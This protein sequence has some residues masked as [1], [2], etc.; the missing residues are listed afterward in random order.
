MM[1]PIAS[2]LREYNY[3]TT[4]LGTLKNLS[5][6]DPNAEFL[7][8][9]E[10]EQLVDKYAPRTAFITKTATWTYAEFDLYAN[11]VANWAVDLR[12]V[13]GDTVALFTRNRLEYVA[14]WYG[15]SKVGV[16]AALVNDLLQGKGLAHCLAVAETKIMLTEPGLMDA[17]ISANSHLPEALSLWCFDGGAKGSQDFDTAIS[18]TSVERPT[19]HLRAG[20]TGRETLLKMFTSGTTG[21][22]K[23]VKVSHVRAQRYMHSFSVATG[24]CKTDR[25]MMVLPMYH[26]TGGLCGVGTALTVGAAV[27]VEQG[28]SARKF[29]QTAAEHDATLFTYVGE[30][31]RFLINTET[32]PA[33]TKHSIRAMLGNGLRPEVWTEFQRRF[34][35]KTIAEFYGATEGNV[36]LMNADGQVGAMG[37]IPWYVKKAFNL[38][39][40][41]HDFETSEVVRA[42]DGSC[43]RVKLGDAGE[44]I[45]RIDPNDPRFLF[46]GYGNAKDTKN[47]ILT[48]VFEPGDRYF[49]TGDLM[50]RDRKAYYYFV[51]RIGDTFRWMAQ[52]VATGEVAAVL[53]AFPG[54]QSANVYGVEVPGCD[55]KAGMAAMAINGAFDG[56]ALYAWLEQ[57]LPTYARPLFLRL[58]ENANT[59]GTF[60]FKKTDLVAQ[61]FALHKTSDPVF[62]LDK[63]Q[64]AY[65]ALTASLQQE[66]LAG[67]VRF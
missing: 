62:V 42:E 36:G 34:G 60:K 49:R 56:K 67:S 8:A 16:Q 2:L 35:V 58:V 44:A 25:M 26:A 50:R 54:V 66:I 38:E 57:Q 12:L 19:R 40:V 47:K 55:G 63:V 31:C 28:F 18:T 64:K 27:I 6:I 52:N 17:A 59:T 20:I 39:L 41:A 1:N 4:M 48:D 7:V 15:L 21:L 43:V 24:A 22:P 10:F 33:D 30:L 14:I 65:V 29:W 23:A 46:E 11:R 5:H 13:P 9:D 32:G 51:D 45:G 3:L 61:G 53:S 37:R